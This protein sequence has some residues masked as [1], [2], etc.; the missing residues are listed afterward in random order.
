[1]NAVRSLAYTTAFY[2]GS[3]PYVLAALICIPFGQPPVIV[4][5]RGW[6]RF[7][8]FCARWLLGSRLVVEGEV[9]RTGVIVA[10]KH[11]SFFE[12]FEVLRLFPDPP[13][14]VVFKAELLDIPLWGRVAKAHGVIPVARE[15]G[16]AAMR[17]ML[18]AGRAATAA[19]RPVIIFPEGTRVPHGQMPP[20]R[21]G[22]AGLYKMLGLP[23]VPIAMDSGRTW[24]WK[25][26]WKRPGTIT[27]RVGEIIPVGL[28]REEVEQR[29]FDA[30]NV[31]NRA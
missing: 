28:P 27:F 2:I 18:T 13:P 10:I 22:V 25:S 17:S 6:A 3:V 9:P 14:A 21:P 5:T 7:H 30:I 23:I 16:A 12:T 1:M 4:I 26:L 15:A 31:L 24:G 19:G 8:H 29:V 11:E 20:L